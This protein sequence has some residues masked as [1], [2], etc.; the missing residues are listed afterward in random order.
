MRYMSHGPRLRSSVPAGVENAR[1]II[2]CYYLKDPTDPQWEKDKAYLDWLEFMKKYYAGGD[3][4]DA[5]NVYGY[6]VSQTVVEVLK[7]CGD[8][9]TRENIMKQAA[10]LDLTLPMLLPGIN[11][12]TSPTDFFPIERQQ[13]V[14]WDG[15]KWASFGKVYGP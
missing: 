15:K 13:L 9:L 12:K 3:M 10:S 1:D 4:K 8:T 7:K 11:I 6:T 5:N 14:K 2:S